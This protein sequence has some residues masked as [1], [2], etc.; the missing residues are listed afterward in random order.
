MV[1]G[2]DFTRGLHKG[3]DDTLTSIPQGGKIIWFCGE[4][5][6]AKSGR[7]C[8]VLVWARE[9]NGWIKEKWLYPRNVSE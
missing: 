7:R 2:K 4:I 3:R 8:S 5:A 9:G 6:R 1:R